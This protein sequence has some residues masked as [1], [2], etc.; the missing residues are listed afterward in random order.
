MAGASEFRRTA[1]VVGG[2][3]LIEPEKMRTPEAALLGTR[4]VLGR[5]GNRVVEAMIRDPARRMAGAVEDGPEDQHLLNEPVGPKGFMSEH[6]VIA[7]RCAE[8]TEGDA[9]QRHSNNLEA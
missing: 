1:L 5:V 8:T 9:E 4:D 6:A 3:S 7:N 2:L